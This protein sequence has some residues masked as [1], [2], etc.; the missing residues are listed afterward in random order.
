MSIRMD[1]TIFNG[2]FYKDQMC[3]IQNQE[4]ERKF[5]TGIM[6]VNNSVFLAVNEVFSQYQGNGFIGLGPQNATDDVSFVFQLF[7]Q[8][9]IDKLIVGLNFENPLDPNLVSTI[10]FGYF[11]INQIQ[12]GT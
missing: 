9:V 11:D 6:C 1:H 4:R 5:D 12:N 10:T 2:N 3:L 8:N 7:N